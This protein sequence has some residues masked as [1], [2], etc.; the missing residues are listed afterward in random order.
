MVCKGTCPVCRLRAQMEGWTEGALTSLGADL[1]PATD[2]FSTPARVLRC[3]QSRGSSRQ[4]ARP[5][6]GGSTHPMQSTPLPTGFW[7]LRLV[8]IHLKESQSSEDF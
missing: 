3:Q 8:L 2:G 1:T 5:A 4:L 7:G 6:T